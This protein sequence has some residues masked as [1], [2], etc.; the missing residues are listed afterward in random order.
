MI[1][2]VN[3]TVDQ[4]LKVFSASCEFIWH[5]RL[6]IG[7]PDRQK[8]PLGSLAPPHSQAVG[9]SG[10]LSLMD[11]TTLLFDVDDTLYAPACGIWDMI[12]DRMD[13]FIHEQL[14]VDWQDIPVLRKSLF[15]TYGTTLRG[16]QHTY[17]ID[18]SEFL[19]Y[20][21]DVPVEERIQASPDL[22]TLLL[23][24]TPRRMIFT[25]ADNRHAR[26]VLNALGILHC[27]EKIIDIHD[28]APSC[29]PHPDAYRKAV[30]LVGEDDPGRVLVLDD[31]LRN[32]AGAR[33]IG[34]YTVL[35]GS[36][37]SLS[38]VL[39]SGDSPPASHWSVETLFDLP[40]VFPG[41]FRN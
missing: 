36:R 15:E 17:G 27:F 22:H 35:V 1:S 6:A 29:K 32:L 23:R 20:V 16:L 9:F 8:K 39:P 38:R 14:R 26:R 11:F 40:L 24:L 12:G 34:C 7:H 31:S 18:A 4:T 41:L 19:A 33:A 30:E 5:D 2:P 3:Y 21:H 37:G 25:N 13:M 28:I 10:I